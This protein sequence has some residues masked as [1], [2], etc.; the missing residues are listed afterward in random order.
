MDTRRKLEDGWAIQMELHHGTVWVDE[1]TGD[2]V[3]K[4]EAEGKSID[5]GAS[6]FA[7]TF[8]GKKAL[9][10]AGLTLASIKGL[11]KVNLLKIK[12]IA[13]KTAEAILDA[14]SE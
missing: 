8:P 3:G 12:G 13:D 1:K 10:E 11:D 4:V 5:I 9:E 7:N 6:G 2:I 14:L